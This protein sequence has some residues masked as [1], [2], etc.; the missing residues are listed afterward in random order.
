M[1]DPKALTQR[2]L[3]VNDDGIDARGLAL[4]ERIVNRVSEEVWVVAPDEERSGA[5]QSISLSVPIRARA[6]GPRRFA[7]KGTPADCVMLAVTTLMKDSPPTLVLS[8]VNHGENL[9]DDMAY[10]GTSSAAMEATQFGLPAI[11]FSQVRQLGQMPNFDAAESHLESVLRSLLTIDWVDGLALN[12]NF[13]SAVG[14]KVSE[15]RVVP[16]GRRPR[17]AFVPVEGRDGRNIPYYWVGVD[18]AHDVDAPPGTDLEAVRQNAI[19]ITALRR[20]PTFAAVNDQL[21]G[22]FQHD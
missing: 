14:G 10:S 3:L 4:L 13:P 6:L 21:K 18:Y 11:A 17:R 5:A 15:I 2:V 7:I 20:D 9:G 12:V 22:V 8:G 19:S 1:N 16:A